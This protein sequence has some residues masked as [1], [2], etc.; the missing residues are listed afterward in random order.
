M[1]HASPARGKRRAAPTSPRVP[2]SRD[3]AWKKSP[4]LILSRSIAELM[5]LSPGSR[6]KILDGL[7]EEEAL[8][9]F[10]EWQFWARE[11]QRPPPGEWLY[12]LILA[13]RGA[14]KTRAGAEV[15]REWARDFAIVNLIGPTA[16]DVRDVMVLG[17]SGL[18][19]CCPPD[20]RPE[21]VKTARRL[22]WP[23]GAV[24][25]LFSAEEPDR[26]RGKQHMKLWCDEIAAWRRPDAFEQALLG[27]RLGSKPQAV[28]T[29]TPRPIKLI[30]TLVAD[31]DAIVTRGSTF[32]NRRHLAQAFLQRITERYQ[33]RDIGR[34]E[35]FA[36]IVE[37]APGA[38]WTRAI[39]ERQRLSSE[40]APE[41]CARV[42]V[43]VDPPAKSGV[44]VDEC[45]IIVVGKGDNGRYYVLADCSSQGESP[46]GWAARVGSAYRTYK[47]DRV[48]AEVN[49][50]GDMV[51]E[52]LRQ[53]DP[54]LPVRSVV[55]TRGKYLRA[56]P[57][58]AAYER[59]IVHHVGEFSK[60]EDQMCLMTPDFDAR[61]AGFSP[62]RADALVWG[63]TELMRS[64]A[65]ATT[66][67]MAF[68]AGL[69]PGGD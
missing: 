28:I 6:S 62:D 51:A 53:S 43:A 64:D 22:E 4:R 27:L 63:L 42:V 40:G 41:S 49:N 47:A 17:E 25:S 56:E 3:A 14:G 44:G 15:V 48:V 45:G 69:K 46:A 59:G 1:T 30:K 26:L 57:I 11:D 68:Y 5:L 18:L 29:T 65:D 52:V 19:A 32:D 54:H 16:E 12:W 35:L 31:R 10:Y 13:G 58:A 38:L 9:L 36:E 61:A 55:A 24:S 50:G 37:E 33:G 66:G 21:Y 23:N 60:L 67:M 8:E 7:T 2:R 39:L 20:E 34:Q